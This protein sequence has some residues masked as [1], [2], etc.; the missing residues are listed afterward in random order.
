MREKEVEVGREGRAH[1]KGK[2]QVGT[3]FASPP[4]NLSLQLFSSLPRLFSKSKRARKKRLKGVEGW[5][6]GSGEEGVVT[7]VCQR[8]KKK[9]ESRANPAEALAAAAVNIKRP[10]G[11]TTTRRLLPPRGLA[12]AEVGLGPGAEQHVVGVVHL[13]VRERERQGGGAAD[14][15]AGGVVLAAVARALELVLGLRFLGLFVFGG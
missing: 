4:R 11:T 13:G 2:G 10:G 14:L 15:L 7:F 12:G 8:A 6:R 9:T 3:S 5:E 1:V